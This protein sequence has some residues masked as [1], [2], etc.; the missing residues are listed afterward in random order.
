[1]KPYIKTTLTAF[2][3]AML[4]WSCQKETDEQLL[5]SPPT[6]NAGPSQAVQLPQASITLTGSGTTTNG[7]ITAYLWSLVSGP[8]VP[9]INS[10]GSPTTTVTGLIAGTYIFQLMVVDN[11]GLTGVDTTKITCTQAPI[12]TLS[13]QPANNTNEVHFAI[14]GGIPQSD[15][16]APELVAASWTSGGAPYDFRGAFKFDLSSIP[17]S[18]TILTAS[19]TL[20]SNPTPLN[21]D[22]VNANS[23][24]NNSMYIRRLLSNWSASTLTWSNQPASSVSDQVL[25]PH[26][27]AS[28]LDLTN[29]DVKAQVATMV[30]TGNYGFL[31][32]LQNE[33]PYNSRI[34]CSSKYSNTSKHPKLVITYQ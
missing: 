24:P 25:I 22:Q 17:A 20:Y 7:T 13:L 2:L 1:M 9:V 3:S 27:L 21:G 10:P 29:I 15:P 31:I 5:Q 11:A 26:T 30:T 4:F 16:N 12:Q 28:F 33:T 32:G 6:A 34:F 14:L 18:A 8:N 23:G 19:L